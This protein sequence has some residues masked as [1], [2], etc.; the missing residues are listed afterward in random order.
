M[1]NVEA[2]NEKIRKVYSVDPG[3][4]VIVDKPGHP[5]YQKERN[6]EPVTREKVLAIA[7]GPPASS[8]R[9]RK[10]DDGT[11]EVVTGRQRVKAACVANA[12]GCGIPYEGGLPSV[13]E[14]IAELGK[15][16]AL[17]G[18]IV[19]LMAGTPRRLTAEPA[20]QA[21]GDVRGMMATENAFA[22][23]E[24]R[25]AVIRA[26]QQ[27]VNNFEIPIEI[28]AERRGLKLSTARKYLRADPDVKPKKPSRGKASG[29][30]KTKIRS[31]L[32]SDKI[33]EDYKALFGFLLGE[34]SLRD[35]FE[36]HPDL[37]GIVG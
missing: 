1:P 15:D 21:I 17:V 37:K 18:R 13:E 10:A 36:Q 16:N 9:L 28:A 30:G 6:A 34:V 27:D 33:G 12:L 22:Q 25:S 3:T 8:I 29:P 31:W 4:V 19:G 24:A 7:L 14:A 5:L 20:N 2:L 35:L 32:K 26:L 11:S 23:G